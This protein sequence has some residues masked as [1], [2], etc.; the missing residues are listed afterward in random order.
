MKVTVQTIKWSVVASFIFLILAY[1]FSGNDC[2]SDNFF[3][4]LCSGI[5]SSLLVVILCEISR[6]RSLKVDT[7]Q[8]I[9]DI[10]VNL[11]ITLSIMK[12]ILKDHIEH[13][14]EIKNDM[15]DYFVD[16]FKKGKKDL[17]SIDYTTFMSS[18][19]SLMRKYTYIKQN[20][21]WNRIFGMQDLN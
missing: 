20:Y 8:C 17:E 18:K 16:N 3:G 1:V 11:F 12:K 5:F 7:G 9:Y 6:Y 21:A 4:A 15:L 10:N 14:T 2:N 19:N 13:K